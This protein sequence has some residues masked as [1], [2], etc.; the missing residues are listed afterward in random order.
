M[1]IEDVT[2]HPGACGPHFM[3]VMP[4]QTEKQSKMYIVYCTVLRFNFE[5]YMGSGMYWAVQFKTKK[6][7]LFCCIF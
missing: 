2:P 5:F 7:R 6:L 3:T 1:N 4:S